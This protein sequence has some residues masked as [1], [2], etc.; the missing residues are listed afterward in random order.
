MGE[1]LRMSGVVVK[2]RGMARAVQGAFNASEKR[3]FLEGRATAEGLT[4]PDFLGIGAQKAGSSWL[5]E[6][7]RCHPELFLPEQ[8]E[9][10]FFDRRYHR[11]LRLYTSKFAAAGTRM[12]GEITPAYSTLPIDRIQLIGAVNPR[13]KILLLIRDPIERAWSHAQMHLLEKVAVRSMDEVSEQEFFDHFVGADSR[14][15][16]N[17]L[18]II[19]HWTSVF[20]RE[21][22]YIGFFEDISRRPQELLGDVFHHLG[23]SEPKSW[24]GFPFRQIVNRGRKN[25]MPLPFRECLEQL[26]APELALLRERFGDRVAAW[27][28]RR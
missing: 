12:K 18:E 3:A 1:R 11:S 25:P 20:P 5:W 21:Q 27:G 22:I 17:Y 13:L 26:Y 2:L 10:H 7:L 6:N 16:G 8:K 9:L 24:D 19:A 4:F 28:A 23:V 14:G 15:K